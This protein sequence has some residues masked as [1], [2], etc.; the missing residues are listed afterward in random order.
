MI[1]FITHLCADR[2]GSI[3][4]RR[5]NIGPASMLQ[6]IFY[7]ATKRANEAASPLPMPLRYAI[8]CGAPVSFAR[9]T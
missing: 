1:G 8:G 7:F 2:P 9:K 4:T 6:C 3:M 5:V